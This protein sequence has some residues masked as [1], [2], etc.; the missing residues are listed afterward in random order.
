MRFSIT[1]ER[2]TGFEG[3][4]GSQLAAGALQLKKSPVGIKVDVSA[5]GTSTVVA[6][7]L[8]DRMR[9]IGG[10]AYGSNRTYSGIF[11]EIA[12]TIDQALLELD[13]EVLL[14]E[15]AFNSTAANI[16]FLER[17]NSAS[18]VA[19]QKAGDRVDQWLGATPPTPSTGGDAQVVIAVPD[20]EAILDAMRVQG[21]LTVAL[22]VA[23]KPGSMPPALAA[24]VERVATAIERVL[25]A[26][27][28]GGIPVIELETGDK[29]V[30]TFL[31]DQARIRTSLPMRTL[32]RCTTCRHEKVTNPDYKALVERNRKIR[33]IGGLLGAS[34]SSAGISPFLLVGRIL[35]LVKMDPDYVCPRCQGLDAD[36]S[37]IV[38]C[39]HCGE[40]RDEPA[41]R[42]CARCEH[43]FR[44]V[45]KPETL[46]HPIGTAA[47]K[48][49]PP[50][51]PVSMAPVNAAS[52]MLAPTP[53]QPAYAPGFYGDPAGRYEA[54]WW[55]GFQWTSQVII[56]GQ[57]GVDA[58]T[59]STESAHT[60]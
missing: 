25:E 2:V 32:Q 20:A 49:A 54:R 1:A 44:A 36:E 40:R 47:A 55:D 6:V 58:T 42:K 24:D 18:G 50:S 56:D 41:L 23:R 19:G 57:P 45:L 10:K 3:Q 53:P 22:L 29:P 52:A 11:T 33:G 16:G 31:N 12:H 30:V 28:P 26:A 37:L 5:E 51:P 43:D 4:R 27:S 48:F 59:A 38:F 17:T 7:H 14:T 9:V 39:P 46:W 15:P 34:I 13:P 21:M 8:Y 35:P 60:A